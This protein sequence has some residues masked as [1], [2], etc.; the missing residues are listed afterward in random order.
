MYERVWSGLRLAKL[1]FLLPTL[2][3]T[4]NPPDDTEEERSAEELVQHY[5]ERVTVS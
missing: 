4:L 3:D 2:T 5:M 1:Q